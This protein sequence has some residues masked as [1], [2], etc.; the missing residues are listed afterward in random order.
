MKPKFLLTSVLLLAA[1][2]A[3]PIQQVY[4]EG[5][6]M[7]KQKAEQND[8][9]GKMHHKMRSFKRIAKKLDLSDEQR[10][11]VKEI[12]EQAKIKRVTNKEVMKDYKLQVKNL[13]EAPVFDDEAFNDLHSQ[14]QDKFSEFALLMA[15]NKHAISQVLTTEQREKLAKLKQKN[16]GGF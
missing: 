5:N 8:R 13:I 6:Q 1:I 14:Y 2:S 7:Q 3:A 10:V 11:K 15:K 16:R 12:F 9:R 4:A